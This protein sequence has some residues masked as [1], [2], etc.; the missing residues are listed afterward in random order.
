MNQSLKYSGSVQGRA[1]DKKEGGVSSQTDR[2]QRE[3]TG[4]VPPPG[5]CGWEVTLSCARRLQEQQYGQEGSED[6]SE[7]RPW[8]SEGGAALRSQQRREQGCRVGHDALSTRAAETGGLS[9][10]K[11]IHGL[12]ERGE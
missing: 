1:V 4:L 7:V 3:A 11:V 12:R 2:W 10:G 9:L 6:S 5:D 8:S